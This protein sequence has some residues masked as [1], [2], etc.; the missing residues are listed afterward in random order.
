MIVSLKLFTGNFNIIKRK[1]FVTTL[2]YISSQADNT[3]NLTSAQL[4][5]G[6]KSLKRS[7]DCENEDLGY[8]IASYFKHMKRREEELR[9]QVGD[10]TYENEVSEQDPDPCKRIDLPN[11]NKKL[12]EALNSL[13]SL[14]SFGLG[15]SVKLTP[16]DSS[17][18]I[19]INKASVSDNVLP[20]LCQNIK[21]LQIESLIPYCK[22]SPFGDLVEHKTK[23]D[24]NIRKA[25]EVKAEDISFIF[26]KE[27][28]NKSK[29]DLD[30][31]NDIT[32][33]ISYS[34]FKQPID[35]SFYKLNV[36]SVGGHFATHVDTPT[37]ANLF[38]GSL[39]VS[40]PSQHKG[41]ALKVNHQ[42]QQVSFDFSSE[43]NNKDVVQ[44]ASFFGDCTH[45]I[46]EV[47]E[48][49]RITLAYSVFR[50]P[51]VVVV[52]TD[53]SNKM[54][55]ENENNEQDDDDN[56]DNDNDDGDKNNNKEEEK[57]KINITVRSGLHQQ[58]VQKQ[59]LS[60]EN[61][62]KETAIKYV[63]NNNNKDKKQK[64]KKDYYWEKKP[65]NYKVFKKM[66]IFGVCLSH[67][68]TQSGLV[69]EGLKGSDR[70]L[71]E[72][73]SNKSIPISLVSIVV[74]E[75]NIVPY[76]DPY[77]GIDSDYFQDDQFTARVILVND[78]VKTMLPVHADFYN[79]KDDKY[80]EE[81]E[82]KNDE[83]NEYNNDNNVYFY[84]MSPDV[85][86]GEE[87]FGSYHEGV[88]NGNDASDGENTT[89][90]FKAAMIIGP[91]NSIL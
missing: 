80:E 64:K 87:I 30:F 11:V 88:W 63:N 26:D 68:Y 79:N 69:S 86:Q 72:F 52:A 17:C 59:L 58:Q 7:I 12:Q 51:T 36:Y 74:N 10:R 66:E 46:E 4:L 73:L 60:I 77:E 13:S 44:F 34:V 38:L 32:K 67:L 65:V 8:D 20:P 53:G 35:V 70:L 15:G 5:E 2:K 19:Q 1:S 37:D 81:N 28:K 49:T 40:L 50:K 76:V 27:K 78:K 16:R 22:V 9:E 31:L 71:Y 55:E 62:I 14:A 6:Y 24:T 23:I 61:A 54:E 21:D 83:K 84:S 82:G 56:N 29:Y 25:L 75:S 41:G 89:S 43:S 39:I 18:I 91:F 47:T 48:G 90:Y 45:E 3:A 57:S 42:G 85:E 33:E